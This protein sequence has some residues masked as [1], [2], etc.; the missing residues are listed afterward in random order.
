MAAFVQLEW[1]ISTARRTGR[2]SDCQASTEEFSQSQDASGT[3]PVLLR[4]VWPGCEK[5]DRHRNHLW[6]TISQM[7]SV[8]CG[9]TE[10]D[11]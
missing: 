4:P 1:L 6:L 5:R 3:V 9:V 7:L 8:H 2:L 10:F 11:N